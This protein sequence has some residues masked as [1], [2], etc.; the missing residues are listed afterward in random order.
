M[1]EWLRRLLEGAEVW[2]ELSS[3]HDADGSE[4]P[5]DIAIQE[6]MTADVGPWYEPGKRPQS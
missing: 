3:R 1:S 5:E 2:P 6:W 4:W